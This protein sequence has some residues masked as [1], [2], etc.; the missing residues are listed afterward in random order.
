MDL[1]FPKAPKKRAIFLFQPFCAFVQMK[2]SNTSVNFGCITR[3]WL[4]ITAIYL[5]HDTLGHKSGMGI[6]G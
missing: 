4:E 2:K 3:Q 1:V 5:F 6:V